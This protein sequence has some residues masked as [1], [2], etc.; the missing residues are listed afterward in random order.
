MDH[1]TNVKLNANKAIVSCAEVAGWSVIENALS[2]EQKEPTG[3]ARIV[4]RNGRALMTPM[5]QPWT[6]ECKD[7]C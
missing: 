5:T 4:P 6:S 1:A 7:F 2:L 3:T